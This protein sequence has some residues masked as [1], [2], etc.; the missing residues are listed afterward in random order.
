MNNIKR[1]FASLCVAFLILS[2]S[3]ASAPYASKSVLVLY[4]A[5][6]YEGTGEGYTGPILLRVTVS[7]QAITDIEVLGHTET[8]GLGSVAIEELSDTVIDANS[9]DVDG[10]SGASASSNGFLSAVEDALLKAKPNKP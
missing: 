9:T 1:F 7:S 5:G 3:C 8:P 6:T 10:I 4:N 2:A